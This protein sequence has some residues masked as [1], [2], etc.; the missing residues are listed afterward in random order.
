MADAETQD[1]FCSSQNDPDDVENRFVDEYLYLF[2]FKIYRP[3]AEAFSVTNST[4]IA[5]NSFQL[6]V[7]FLHVCLKFVAMN[8]QRLQVKLSV[9]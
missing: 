9:A 4:G 3:I 5:L 6:N 2:A 7:D 1:D 8:C